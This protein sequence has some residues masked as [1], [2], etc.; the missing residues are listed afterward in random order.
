M[1]TDQPSTFSVYWISTILI[2]IIAICGA[3][4]AIWKKIY[5]KGKDD[6]IEKD[7]IKIL[8]ARVDKLEE[9][10]VTVKE[11]LD[12]IIEN[13]GQVAN[14]VAFIKGKMSKRD[15]TN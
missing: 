3:V 10:V 5:N 8:K 12:K 1:A 4:A 15:K 9:D 6:Q 11:K 13:T 14:D 2:T 7:D